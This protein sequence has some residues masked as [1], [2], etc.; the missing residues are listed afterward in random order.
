MFEKL[1]IK[2][3]NENNKANL[4]PGKTRINWSALNEKTSRKAQK[5]QKIFKRNPQKDPTQSALSLDVKNSRK[6]NIS[7]YTVTKFHVTQNHATSW[8]HIQ[9]RR[10]AQKDDAL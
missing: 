6:I 5:Q 8:G 9:T 3:R 10:Y 2:K 7:H 1:T 4:I